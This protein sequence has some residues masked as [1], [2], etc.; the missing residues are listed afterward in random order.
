MHQLKKQ[1]AELSSMMP[2]RKSMYREFPGSPMVRTQGFHC[3]GPGS[4]PG[5]GT[6]IPQAMWHDQEIKI[7]KKKG[8]SMYTR[9]LS[10][11]YQ[12]PYG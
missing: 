11:D 4:I 1:V 10:L 12:C 9:T 5:Q 8:K 3:H 7:F 6:K 2:L